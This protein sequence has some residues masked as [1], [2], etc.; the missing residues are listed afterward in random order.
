MK[1]AI[2]EIVI[3]I[4]LALVIFM[5]IRTVAYNFEVSGRSMEPNLHNGQFVMISKIIYWFD[6]PQRGDIVVYYSDMAEHHVIHRVVGLPGET[7]ALKNGYIYIN[8]TQLSEPYIHDESRTI[9]PRKVP[10][11]EYYIVGD[12]RDESN[13][14]LVPEEDIVGKAWICYWPMSEWGSISNYSW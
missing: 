1:N 12:N 3:T 6:A 14:E 10:Q 8:G 2:R 5:A 13:W 9:P 4:L 7:V 11:G